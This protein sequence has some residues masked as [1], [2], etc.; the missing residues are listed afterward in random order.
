MHTRWAYACLP[1]LE[2][3]SQT[4][5]RADGKRRCP[6]GGA[7]KK[8]LTVG[9]KGHRFVVYDAKVHFPT[10]KV[11]DGYMYNRGRQAY[12]GYSSLETRGASK[13]I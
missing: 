7:M 2:V 5:G 12:S 1:P 3:R 13:D 8:V 6:R 4:P 9:N 10:T 11:H